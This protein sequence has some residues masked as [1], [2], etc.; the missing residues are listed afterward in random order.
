M[1]KLTLALAIGLLVAASG[2]ISGPSAALAST[3]VGSATTT[4]TA[5]ASSC[6]GTKVVIVVG[7]VQ[8][9][10]AQ[11][12]NDARAA[13]AVFRNYTSCVTEIYSP[14]AT[15]G[16]V[17]NAAKGA[18]IL[19]Y[20]GHGSGYPNPYNSYL[21]PNGDNGM[22]LNA[23]AGSSDSRTYYYGE[24]YMAQLQLAPNA[25]VILNHLCYAS[26]NSESQYVNPSL[27]TAMVR[28]EGYAG[29]FI[30]AGAAAVIA[31]GTHDI[32][33][34]IDTVFGSNTTVDAMWKN[35]PSFHGNVYS[36][37]GSRDP[38]YTSQIDP[39]VANA[40]AGGHEVYYRSMVSIPTTTTNS[41]INGR[42]S[43]FTP[44]SGSYFPLPPTRVVDSRGNG[45]GPTGT[46]TSRIGYT[47]QIAGKKV[48]G[49]TPVP[50]NAIAITANVTVTA[51]TAA[52]W[53]YVG[54]TMDATPTVSTINFPKGD[55]RANGVTI[56]LSP[57]GRIG[58]FYGTGS[59]ATAHLVI[60]VTGYFLPGKGGSGYTKYGPHRVLDT[61]PG[62]GNT[63]LTGKFT[64]GHHRTIQIAGV[65][66]LPA[67]GIVAVTGNLT[68]VNPSAG[69]WVSLGRDQ[70]DSPSSSTINFPARDIRANNVVV[71]VNADGTVSAFYSAPAGST[72]DLLLDV[73][74]YFGAGGYLFNTMESVRILDS[75]S[76]PGLTGYFHANVPRTL[77]VTGSGGVPSGAIAITANLTVTAQNAAGVA[78]VGPQIDPASPFSNLNFPAGDSRAN[79]TTVPLLLPGGSVQLVFNATSSSRVAHL[80]LDVTGYYLGSA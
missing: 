23:V 53:V 33:Y 66:G 13:A 67:S 55:T 48:N 46:L 71:P 14:N 77:Q 30:R 3:A 72:T 6:V 56:A 70:T 7:Q 12:I 15:W 51:T 44:Q 74:G 41:I 39:D 26:G 59:S 58:A 64:A 27:S 21:K 19:V 62:A 1:R 9:T 43:A 17:V 73:S 24:N 61:R 40:P 57:E 52:G 42:L 31:E 20:L 2:T 38:G 80:L 68:V 25:L 65:A 37:N 79:G 50:A 60:D 76:G 16:A 11:Y 49:A 18:N 8:G 4:A 5:N 28:V 36:W 69:G 29:G 32:S 35:A 10:T 63:G 22:G 45:V 47:Y 54:P 34:F 78:A 75:R